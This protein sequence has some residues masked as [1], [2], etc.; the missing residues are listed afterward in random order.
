MA[1]KSLVYVCVCMRTDHGLHKQIGIPMYT[2]LKN[3]I[4]SFAKF[5]LLDSK[6]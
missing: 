1:I 5:Q 2:Y 6:L 4:R 3:N